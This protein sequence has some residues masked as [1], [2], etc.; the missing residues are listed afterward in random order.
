MTIKEKIKNK[1]IGIITMHKVLNFGSAL[2]AYG[3]QY[4]IKELGFE[5]C[6]IDYD[7]PNEFHNRNTPKKNIIKKLFDGNFFRKLKYKLATLLWLDWSDQKTQF[8]EFYHKYY[9]LSR[10]YHSRTELLTTPPS[11]SVVVVGSDQVWNPNHMCGDSIFFGEFALNIP[12]ISFASS[13][14]VSQIPKEFKSLYKSYLNKFIALGV[15]E[16]NGQ[17]IINELLGKA[18]QIVCD[19]ALLLGKQRCLELAN[20]SKISI[21]KP[22]IL[23]YILD[24]NFNPHPTIDRLI[25]KLSKKY[26]LDV[27]YLQC[28]NIQGSQ[29]I[30]KQIFNA[31][32]IDFLNLIKHAKIVITSSFH[33]VALSALLEKDFYTVIDS[34]KDDDRIFSFCN[35][36]GT[37]DRI[38]RQGCKISSIKSSPMNW[39]IITP[40]LNHLRNE[41]IHFLRNSIQNALENV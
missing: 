40:R 16:Q 27:V 17:T 36:I 4:A 35:K 13:F 12:R 10:P 1:P 21:Q 23:A 6:I 24:Y 34:K 31:G 33:G 14:V 3:L 30:G 7:F 25:I 9:N 8:I 26:N 38:I 39:E 41:S 19:P 2:Q 22:Y 5:V 15:R 29:R 11:L 32:Q 18:S 28:G 20:N 37:T